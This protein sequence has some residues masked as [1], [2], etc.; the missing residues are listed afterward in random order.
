MSMNAHIQPARLAS[1]GLQLRHQGFGFQRSMVL[2]TDFSLPRLIPCESFAGDRWRHSFLKR[3]A[4]VPG[5]GLYLNENELTKRTSSNSRI[6]SSKSSSVSPES[7]QSHLCSARGH[8]VLREGHPLVEDTFRAYKIA[9]FGAKHASFRFEPVNVDA[10]SIAVNRDR[11][12]QRPRPYLWDG[13]WYIGFARRRHFSN[14]V[15]KLGKG[16][17]IRHFQS[18]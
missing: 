15:Q 10:T 12:E 6:V 14:P 2:R 7:R 17:F 3:N 4:G 13:S 5:R 8:F 1:I 16:Y 11:P 9:S 18:V